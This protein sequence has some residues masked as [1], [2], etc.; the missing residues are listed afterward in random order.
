MLQQDQLKGQNH[1]LLSLLRASSNTS[2]H[3]SYDETL[4]RFILYSFAKHP[5][6]QVE[7][8]SKIGPTQGKKASAGRRVVRQTPFSLRILLHGPQ[9]AG[10]GAVKSLSLGRTMFIEQLTSINNFNWPSP[11]RLRFPFRFRFRPPLNGGIRT[12]VVG[13][14]CESLHHPSEKHRAQRSNK[15]ETI[16]NRG[17]IGEGRRKKTILVC[18]RAEG[19]GRLAC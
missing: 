6:V 17:R 7:P 16:A 8:I 5:N 11:V 12:N 13:C 18:C 15:T 19:V 14:G 9:S 2:H 4:F 1:G 10:T 3:R